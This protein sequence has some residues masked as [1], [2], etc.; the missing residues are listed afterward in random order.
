MK[1]KKHVTTRLFILDR[2]IV[3]LIA[4]GIANVVID[5]NSVFIAAVNETIM[6]L[7]TAVALPAPTKIP[8]GERIKWLK[9]GT[10][11]NNL[12]LETNNTIVSDIYGV[13]VTSWIDIISLI[14]VEDNDASYSCEASNVIGTTR[15]T[16]KSHVC[17]CF[18]FS[19]NQL[20][21]NL[22]PCL[23]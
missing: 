17:K 19:L 15:K 21:F 16:I 1:V 2:P 12:N 13:T 22:K 3:T 10:S 4:L 8:T 5:G 7:C 20:K 6:L 23:V 14:D 11:L 9:D 18:L